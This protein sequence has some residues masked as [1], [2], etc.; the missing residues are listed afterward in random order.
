MQ[1][2]TTLTAGPG[3]VA[4]GLKVGVAWTGSFVVTNVGNAN[5]FGVD[6]KFL[7][8]IFLSVDNKLSADDVKLWEGVQTGFNNFAM[9]TG[10]FPNHYSLPTPTTK[11]T[12]TVPAG[13]AAGSYFLLF[14]INAD[15]LFVEPLGGNL[16]A[17][18]ASVSP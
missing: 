11:P 12:V 7:S 10:Q 8:R 15:D 1:I 9:Q 3:G 14:Q 6:G 16:F 18:P 2:N 17:K 13:T 5:I 4:V